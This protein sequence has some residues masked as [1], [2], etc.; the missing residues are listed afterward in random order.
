MWD[1]K[2]QKDT[3]DYIFNCQVSVTPVVGPGAM[4]ALTFFC[5]LHLVPPLFPS[6]TSSPPPLSPPCQEPGNVR[7]VQPVSSQL[8]HWRDVLGTD[9][10]LGYS[11]WQENTCAKITSLQVTTHT[12][13]ASGLLL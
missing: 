8:C 2:F 10:P 3:P 6:L 1:L 7:I 5:L 11:Q 9:R 12:F 4:E 13:I